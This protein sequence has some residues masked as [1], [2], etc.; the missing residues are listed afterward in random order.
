M[1]ISVF[2]DTKTIAG[3]FVFLLQTNQ[4]SQALFGQV[5]QYHCRVIVTWFQIWIVKKKHIWRA[6]LLQYVSI[7]INIDEVEVPVLSVFVFILLDREIAQSHKMYGCINKNFMKIPIKGHNGKIQLLIRNV[8]IRRRAT[9]SFWPQG[10][11]TNSPCKM[12]KPTCN[13]FN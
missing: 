10:Y 12:K 1:S 9:S 11:D 13:C 8:A 3:C 6:C 2:D 5:F 7:L 4:D